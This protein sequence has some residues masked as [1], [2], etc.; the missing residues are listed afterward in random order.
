MG[1]KSAQNIMDAINISKKVSFSKFINGL[2]IRNVGMASSKL[3]EIKYNADLKKLKSAT[4]NELMQIPEFG[5]VMAESIVEFFNNSTNNKI[6]KRCLDGGV[7]FKKPKKIKSSSISG[8]TF[9]FTGTL[10]T[11]NRNEAKKLV[12]SFG[13]KASGSVSKNTDYLVAGEKAGS[14][15]TKAKKINITILTESEFQDLIKKL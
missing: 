1:D 6:I 14:K 7:V 15:L 10:N 13:A 9:V 8:K 3:L 5:E 12:E 11:T 4:K 2:G